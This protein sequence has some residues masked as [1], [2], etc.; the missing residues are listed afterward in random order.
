MLLPSGIYQKYFSDKQ[1]KKQKKT[2]ILY[3]G[4]ISLIT[5]K[6]ERNVMFDDKRSSDTNHLSLIQ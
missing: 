3:N 2:K 1:N 5:W 6:A 4:N